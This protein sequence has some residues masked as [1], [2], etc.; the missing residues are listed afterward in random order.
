MDLDEAG[1]CAQHWKD[2][3]I[4]Y[5][6]TYQLLLNNITA[7]ELIP[8]VTGAFNDV[9]IRAVTSNEAT[10]DVNGDGEIWVGNEQNSETPDLWGNLISVS[11]HVLKIPATQ[12]MEE[13]SCSWQTVL[14]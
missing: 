10:V 6:A 3:E 4:Q 7:L 1:L 5:N 14:R 9:S 12:T 2:G 13:E 11:K 8:G